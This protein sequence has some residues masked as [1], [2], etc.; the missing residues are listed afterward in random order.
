MMLLNPWFWLFLVATWLG[1][2][3]GGYEWS[4]GDIKQERAVAQA[5]LE[6]ANQHSKEISDEREATVSK[7]STDLATAQANAARSAKDLRYNITTG[8]L[9]LS[10]PVTSCGNVPNDSTAPGGNNEARAELDPAAAERIVSITDD[11][12]NAIFKLNACI[13]AY[14]SLSTPTENK[15]E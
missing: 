6:A 8:A 2:A 5:A 12:N 3:F 14:N 10:V 1:A 15:N 11:G 13:D 4:Q 9:R 7:I